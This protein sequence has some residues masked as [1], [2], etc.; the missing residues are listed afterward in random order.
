MQNVYV[1]VCKSN[2]NLHHLHPERVSYFFLYTRYPTLVQ[3]VCTTPQICKT[4]GTQCK[5]QTSSRPR[6]NLS[7]AGC[8][9]YSLDFFDFLWTL[10]FIYP[11]G[12]LKMLTQHKQPRGDQGNETQFDWLTKE[13]KIR[14]WLVYG[15][16]ITNKKIINCWRGRGFPVFAPGCCFM[17]RHNINYFAPISSHKILVTRTCA[18]LNRWSS[19]GPIRG[20]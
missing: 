14:F 10:F 6:V 9:I 15:K 19:G 5:T 18:T 2:P 1:G 20:P 11:V 17:P 7:P 4:A 13:F 3:I 16:T 8:W 12:F